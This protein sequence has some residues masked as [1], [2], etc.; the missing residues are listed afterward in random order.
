M[1]KCGINYQRKYLAEFKG[2]FC[3]WNSGVERRHTGVCSFWLCYFALYI[4]YAMICA[5]VLL[6]K[7]SF[8][9]DSVK[10]C[11]QNFRA[12]RTIEILYAQCF[13]FAGEETEVCLN[14]CQG[15]LTVET[16]LSQCKPIPVPRQVGH[17]PM[18]LSPQLPF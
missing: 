9:K 13:H 18:L 10:I 15:P 5:G 2:F 6:K 1:Y 14:V 17:F 12:E 8:G 7:K 11:F 16:N 3:E 4:L